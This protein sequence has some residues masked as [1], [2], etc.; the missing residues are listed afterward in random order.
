MAVIFKSTFLHLEESEEAPVV[1][2]R[3]HS[4]E[5]RV[6]PSH[7]VPYLSDYYSGGRFPCTQDTSKV[8]DGGDSLSSTPTSIGRWSDACDDSE[9]CSGKPEQEMATSCG[10]PAPSSP[11]EATWEP[12]WYDE[13]TGV[14]WVEN[15]EMDPGVQAG[16][17]DLSNTELTTLMLRNIPN[18]VKEEELLEF[19]TARGFEGAYDLIYMP[20]DKRSGCNRGYAFINFESNTMFM[21]AMSALEQC[22]FGSRA[23]NKVTT[24]CVAAVQ[25]RDAVLAANQERLHHLVFVRD[26]D[27][28]EHR[29]EA[30]ARPAGERAEAKRK[31]RSRY[32]A[33]RG[34][35]KVWQPKRW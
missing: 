20:R 9:E 8:W 3:A 33:Q 35:R 23:S 13:T 5:A 18:G 1:R 31:S 12:V 2:R 28:T 29:Q 6:S 30:A 24:A 14:Y 4:A 16:F 17:W 21:L 10:S 32:S 22:Q 34:G 25:G 15:W 11:R 27:G 26:D 7:V 19:L